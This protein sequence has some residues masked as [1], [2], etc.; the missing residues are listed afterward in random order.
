MSSAS[1]RI[2]GLQVGLPV[3]RT[4]RAGRSVITA[5]WKDPVEGRRWL[6]S[7][8]VDGDGQGDPEHHGGL[9][10]ALLGYAA[11][12]YPQWSPELGEQ[13]PFGAFGENVTLGGVDE[14]QVCIGDRW[15][16]GD[17]VVE[18]SQPRQPCWKIDL[19]W[20]R[21]DL[22][23]R[24]QTTGRTGWYHRVVSEGLIGAGEALD[25]LARPNPDWTVR[26]AAA[27]IRRPE[28][29]RADT[30]ALAGVA[31]LSPRLRGHLLG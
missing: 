22:T 9:D 15:Q 31:A 4:T 18:V 27:V 10:M 3:A 30:Q 14:D 28:A 2:V 20:S 24:V 16:M 12:H 11:A 5:F 29:S 1:N 26:R 6:S 8:N 7:T 17:A 21:T 25:L 19:R 13:Y 23:T